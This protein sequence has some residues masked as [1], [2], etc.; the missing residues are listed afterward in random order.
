MLNWGHW[1]HY[2]AGRLLEKLGR[3]EEA[4]AEYHLAFRHAPY[5][6]RA[7]NALGNLHARREDYSGA[8][9]WLAEAARID[10]GNAGILFNLG[11]ARDR[12]GQTESA[13]EVFTQAVGLNPKLDRAWY[14]MGLCHAALDRHEAAANAFEEA[15]ALQPENPVVW[16]QVGMAYHALA[17]RDKLKEVIE[18]LY[19]FNPMM[20]RKLIRDTGYDE[21]AYLVRDLVE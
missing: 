7:A 2:F 19:R 1:R 17:Q 6:T 18:H 16:Y 5:A 20:T 9:Y 11:Y 3:Q 8:E 14:G 10:P 15:A 4:L 13:L 21:L 12:L